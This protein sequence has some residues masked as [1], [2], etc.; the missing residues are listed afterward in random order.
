M[1]RCLFWTTAFLAF[2]VATSTARAQECTVGTGGTMLI[3]TNGIRT[4]VEGTEDGILENG[5]FCGQAPTEHDLDVNL[6]GLSDSDVLTVVQTAAAD[7]FKT[8]SGTD[9]ILV[10]NDTRLHSLRV[11]QVETVGV[12][13]GGGSDEVDA[14]SAQGADRFYVYGGDGDDSLAGSPGPDRLYGEAGNDLLQG[15]AGNDVL[16]GGPGADILQGDEGNDRFEQ[17]AVAD[18]G[19]GDTMDGG[20]GSD[21]VSYAD[22]TGPVWVTL[23]QGSG[24]D[25]EAVEAD[26]VTA[27]ETAVGDAGADPLEGG[28]ARDTLQGGDDSD[29]LD[30]GPGIDSYFG[31]AGD[32][33]LYNFDSA[34]ELVDCGAGIDDAEPD[35]L[36]TFVACEL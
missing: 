16:D 3:T 10:N 23:D 20:P 36:D 4:T 5:A 26:T 15:L 14:T 25:G 32:D 17:G 27:I 9:T 13:A 11:Y 21:T 35:A 22:R 12:L 6:G 34:A 31:D 18:A 1:K 19:G 2:S 30:G 7:S 24:D 33:F 28:R 8:Y 29:V